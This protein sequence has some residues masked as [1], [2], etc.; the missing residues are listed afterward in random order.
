MSNITLS[1]TEET[2]DRMDMHRSIK[3]SSVVRAVIKRKLDDFEEAEALARKSTLT[4]DDVRMLSSKVDKAMA[5]HA[6]KLLNES[7]C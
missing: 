2:K 1:V 5:K 7:N 3:W 4:E 6:R